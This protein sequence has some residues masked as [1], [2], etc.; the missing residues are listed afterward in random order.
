LIETDKQRRWWFATHPEYSGGGGGRTRKGHG[1]PGGGG[2]PPQSTQGDGH[3]KYGDT[4]PSPQSGP[5]ED[6]AKQAFI[7]MMMK[8]GWSREWA[9]SRWRLQKLNESIAWT[10]A[11]ALLVRGDIVDAMRI[12]TGAGRPVTSGIVTRGPRLPPKGTPER[13]KIEAARRRGIN[14]KKGQEL[15]DIQAGGKGSGAWSEKELEGI[16]KSGRFPIDARWHHDPTVA[17]RPDLAADPRYVKPVRGGTKGHFD[18]HGR[19]WRNPRK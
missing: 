19:D 15:A 9:E 11:M 2:W 14:A 7:D 17:N 18:A 8:A 3:D 12:L 13:A 5:S 1:K 4:P 10:T 16:R 6:P